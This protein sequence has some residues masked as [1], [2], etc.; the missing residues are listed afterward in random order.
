MLTVTDEADTYDLVSINDA[1]LAA[2]ASPSLQDWVT[3]ASDVISRHCNRVFRLETVSEQF[4]LDKMQP[5]LLL[6][7]YPNV[8]ITS[9]VEGSITLDPADYEVDPDTGVV[10]RLTNDRP[11]HWSRCKITVVYS[12]GYEEFEDVPPA[13]QRACLELVKAYFDADDRDPRLRSDTVEGL[14]TTTYYNAGDIEHL[15]PEVHGL[16]NQFKKFKVGG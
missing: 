3:R 2:G 9:I 13:L 1:R 10:I 7:R 16:L 6:A 8:I 4:R 14:G 5:E 12:A 11:C 15:S